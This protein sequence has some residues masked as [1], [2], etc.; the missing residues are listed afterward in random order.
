[1]RQFFKF[2]FASMLGVFLLF[3]L[4]FLLFIFIISINSNGITDVDNNSVLELSF[5]SPI[6]ERTSKNPFEGMK[7]PSFKSE[8]SLG[9]NDIIKNIEKAKTDDRIKGIFLNLSSLQA[10]ISTA[11]EIRNALVSFKRAHKFIVAY[12]E[13]YSQGTYYLASVADKIYLNPQGDL[14]FHGLSTELTFFKGALEKL[15]VEPEI[16]RHGKFKSAV[17]PFIS[18]KMSPENKEQISEL[19]R[20]VWNVY[21]D[22]VAEGRKMSHEDLKKIANDMLVRNPEDAL[23]LKMVDG[24]AYMDEV[25]SDLKKMAGIGEK[26]KLKLMALKKYDNAIGLSKP[27][28][29]KKIA[30]IYAVGE[31]GGGDGNDE[32]IGSDRISS[33]I[34]KA[35]TDTSIKAIVLR[36]NSPG[37]SALASDVIWREMVLAKKAKPVVVSMGDVAASGGY[38]ISCAA[39]TIVAQ[40]NT[41]T[42]SIGVFGLLFNAQKMFNNKLGIT[43]DTVRTGKFSEL[44]T[45]TRPL[46]GAEKEIIQNQVERIY[47]TF[48]SHVADGRKMKKTDVDSIGQGRV[49][50]GTDAKHLGL[51]DELGGLNT[52][53]DIAARMAKLDSYRTVSLPEQKEFLQKLMEDFSSE[54]STSITQKELGESYK[55]YNRIQSLLKMKGI[56]ARLPFEIEVF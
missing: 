40:P 39:D 48:L 29:S 7:F 33:A 44:G 42:G 19:L 23:R 21:I 38:Y 53:I 27:F 46:S 10:G 25:Q 18:D 8:S 17:E 11:E 52:A 16:I 45:I 35:R 51:V 13:Y 32:T 50:S 2:M 1:M 20:S 15:D 12:S 36:V 49:W 24:L 37:G 31:I 56:Q 3:T 5:D 47:D 14:S 4:V 30:V 43:F 26:D 9:L 34:R 22:D 41:I 55:Y 6:K 54:T 28:S